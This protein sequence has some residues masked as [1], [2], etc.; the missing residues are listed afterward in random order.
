MTVSVTV[1]H[2]STPGKFLRDPVMVSTTVFR[3]S[4]PGSPQRASMTVLN[5]VTNHTQ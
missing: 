4:T 5:E 1:L 3:I 2:V